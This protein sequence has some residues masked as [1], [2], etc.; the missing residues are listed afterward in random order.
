ML[1]AGIANTGN[2]SW[3]YAIGV[4]VKTLESRWNQDFT[5]TPNIASVPFNANAVA[6]AHFVSALRDPNKKG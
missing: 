2:A 3:S 5:L 4:R 6:R 1:K